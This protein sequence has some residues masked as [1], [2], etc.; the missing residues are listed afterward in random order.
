MIEFSVLYRLSATDKDMAIKEMVEFLAKD[1][2]FPADEIIK[3]IIRRETLG[4]TALSTCAIPHTKHPFI[5]E[6][7]GLIAISPEGIQWDE[8]MQPIRLFCMVLA[9]IGETKD[10][11][12]L[13]YLIGSQLTDPGFC[14]DLFDAQNANEI[15]H[16]LLCLEKT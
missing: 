16:A 13:M 4:S 14:Q 11:L 9:P 1:N 12:R 2:A 7:C 3:S 5:K 10:Y 8:G 6:V 15:K